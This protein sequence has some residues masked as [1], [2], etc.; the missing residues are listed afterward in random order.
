MP[1]RP[2][3]R[4]I[5]ECEHES[6]IIAKRANIQVMKSDF[7]EKLHCYRRLNS[8]KKGKR[9]NET[10]KCQ[11]MASHLWWR[12]HTLIK[13]D[14]MSLE[15]LYYNSTQICLFVALRSPR[16]TRRYS[17]PRLNNKAVRV[18][19]CLLIGCNGRRVIKKPWKFLKSCAEFLEMFFIYEH[20][21]CLLVLF[22]P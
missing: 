6:N 8:Y 9:E 14:R 15:I 3:R 18:L 17:R 22:Y 20:N 12:K 1:Q 21:S 11:V 7:Y 4:D 13:I 2:P 16:K 5:L 10:P 19:V